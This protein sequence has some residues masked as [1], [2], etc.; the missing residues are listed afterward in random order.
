MGWPSRI[1]PHSFTVIGAPLVEK[2]DLG[3]LV[4]CG[5][6]SVQWCLMGGELSPT[7]EQL[8]ECFL[9]GVSEFP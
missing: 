7:A 5:A 8:E 9:E 6:E 1:V 3:G 4:W 2:S